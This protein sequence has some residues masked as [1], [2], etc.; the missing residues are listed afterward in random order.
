MRF[1]ETPLK[2]AFVIE[3]VVHQ[4]HRGFFTETYKEPLFRE[5]GLTAVFIQDNH[6]RSEQPGVLRG[7]HY[8]EPPHAQ[9]KFI[10]ALRGS[11]F[12][13]IVDIRKG[14]QTYGQHF[15]IELSDKNFKMLW[16]PVGFAHGYCTLEL[17]TEVAYKVDSLYAPKQEGGIIWNDPDLGIQWPVE[18]PVLSDKDGK[19][20]QLKNF[21]SPFSCHS[22]E[23]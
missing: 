20:P 2:G 10:R 5:H 15:S 16:V 13:V 22:S 3:P 6:A 7:L 14:S 19:M 1:I 4:D 8:Q 11:I 12:D 18:Q 9:T 17:G 21:D 23:V